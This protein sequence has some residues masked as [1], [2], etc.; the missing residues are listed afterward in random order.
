MKL[1][2]AEA[3]GNVI[4]SPDRPEPRLVERDGFLVLDLGGEPDGAES[5]DHRDGRD[6]RL[7][8]LVEFALRR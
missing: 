4:L 6:E 2:I 5:G 7:R 8:G 3:D 1:R